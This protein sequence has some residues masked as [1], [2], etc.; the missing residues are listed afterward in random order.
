MII[1]ASIQ[2]QSSSLTFV[3]TSESVISNNALLIQSSAALEANISL[4]D[5]I[6]NI[7]IKSNKTF[8]NILLLLKNIILLFYLTYLLFPKLI[9]K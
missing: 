8:L 7:I 1:H 5:I 9:Q 6:Q 2:N 3:V 4:K